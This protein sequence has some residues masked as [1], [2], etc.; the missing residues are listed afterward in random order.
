MILNLAALALVLGITFLHSL[1]GLYSGLINLF[2]S[3]TALAVT[4]GFAE[5]LN[6]VLTGKFG[7][8]SSWT[9]PLA[10]VL[11]FVVTL[12]VLR[13]LA[14]RLLRGNV[15]IPMYPDWGGGAVC[16]F[17]NA[18]IAVGM[19][20]IGFLMLP[21]GGRVLMFSR[22]ERDVDGRVDPLT[23]RVEFHRNSLWLR[24]DEFAVGLAK[25]L[26]GGSLK[27]KTNFARVYPDY[28]EWVFWSGNTVQHESITAPLR[29]E[30]H[31]SSWNNGLQVERWWEQTTPLDSEDTRYR[32]EQPSRERKE[33]R[34]APQAYEPQEGN[35]LIGMRLILKRAAADRHDR[36]SA[37][38]FRPSMIRL[39]GDVK[40]LGV[41]DDPGRPRQ[42]IPQIIGGAD[43]RI[44]ER[45][46]I[47]DLDANFSLPGEDTPIDVYFEVEEGFEPR[48]V[49]YR[50]HARCAVTAGDYAETPPSGRL[51]AAPMAT[52]TGRRGARGRGPARF[53]D[54]VNR[55]ESGDRDRLPFAMNLNRLGDVDLSGERMVRGRIM[56]DRSGLQSGDRRLKYLAIPSGRRIFQL[57]TRARQAQSV[58]GQAMNFAG[59]VTNQYRAVDNTGERHALAGYYAIVERDGQEYLELFF[60]PDPAAEGFNG[61]L[62]FKTDGIRRALRDQDDAV[63]GLIFVVPPESTIES[64][65]VGGAG[66]LNFGSSGFKMRR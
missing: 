2:C 48:F 23:E 3:I 8:H 62:D 21:W 24:S 56:G 32:E 26:S 4:F 52:P 64:I 7:L 22:Y 29:D 65:S 6:E 17:V 55:R 27:G 5:S 37:H 19:M 28:T 47:V 33:P 49:E 40:L 13:Q 38:R 57:Q 10:F 25:L 16:A 42:Y 20:V 36:S 12:L 30:G 43:G 51:T 63:L 54:T 15:R 18:Q 50:R 59:S 14:D 60:T 35:Q 58:L 11:L 34:Y 31:E 61:M 39:V 1:F 46:R 66:T 45:L 9:E 41:P 53:I 44:P